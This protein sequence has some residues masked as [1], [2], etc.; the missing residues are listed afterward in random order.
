MLE[1]IKNKYFILFVVL[2]IGVFYVNNIIIND[3]DNSN[4]QVTYTN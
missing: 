4:N 2:I 1:I 3:Y